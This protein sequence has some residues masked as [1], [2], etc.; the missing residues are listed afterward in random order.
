ML[1]YLFHIAVKLARCWPQVLLANGRGI[2]CSGNRR[3][4]DQQT[5]T[6]S[7]TSGFIAVTT[8][9]RKFPSQMQKTQLTNDPN[10]LT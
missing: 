3:H 10:I 7:T 1:F 2:N 4:D 9:L 6:R 8:Q 5:S